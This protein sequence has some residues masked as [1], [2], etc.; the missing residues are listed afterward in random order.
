MAIH[1]SIDP[2]EP[3]TRSK[4]K[5]HGFLGFVGAMVLKSVDELS[6]DGN[7]A[8]NAAP[9]VPTTPVAK[10]SG[11]A[12]PKAKATPDPKRKGMKRPAS[13][14][15]A[16]PVGGEPEGDTAPLATETEDPATKRKPSLRRPASEAAAKEKP[17][18][19]R[20]NYYKKDNRYGFVVGQREV[21]YVPSSHLVDGA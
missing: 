16:T 19:I 1:K 3:I 18:T 7:H 13:S 8:P 17:L 21:M 10:A 14:V 11:K 9:S 4:C 20:K 5:M 15:K 12:K 2:T 6:D